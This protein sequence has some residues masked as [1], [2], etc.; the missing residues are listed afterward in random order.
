[1]YSQQEYE[2]VRRQTIQIETEKRALL[3]L[4]L[5]LMTLLF[6][7]AL[8]MLGMTYRLY[9]GNINAATA[10]EAK[11]LELE[12]QLQ[13]TSQELQQKKT[14]LE[15]ITNTATQRQDQVTALL[16][17][18]LTSTPN[19]AEVAEFAHA[20]FKLPGRSV[21]APK[22]PP[23]PLFQRFW[24]FRNEGKTEVYS[25][26][27]GQVDGQWIIYANLTGIT[28]DLPRAK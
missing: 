1:M 10:A 5:I 21:A 11:V 27:R 14:E 12:S 8:V 7:A 18:V 23:D 24:R 26:A 13:R 25:L 16:P 20:V 22:L 28:A 4:L 19:S 15:K 9:R 6:V 3:K 2:M 17:K